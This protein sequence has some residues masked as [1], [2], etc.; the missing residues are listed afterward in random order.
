MLIFVVRKSYKLPLLQSI[1]NHFIHFITRSK[2][3]Q[4]S[5]VNF[6]YPFGLSVQTKYLYKTAVPIV[7]LQLEDKQLICGHK[8]RVH[9]CSLEENRLGVGYLKDLYQYYVVWRHWGFR[10]CF[11]W[12]FSI[13]P[14]CCFLCRQTMVTLCSLTLVWG[15]YELHTVYCFLCITPLSWSI[16]L[17]IDRKSVV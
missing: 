6:C 13:L 5:F 2:C 11:V 17:T 1:V 16:N 8:T 10:G 12:W 4:L 7:R 14:R 3:I 9:H 15:D